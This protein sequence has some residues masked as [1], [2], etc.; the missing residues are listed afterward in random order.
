MRI[1]EKDEKGYYTLDN[2]G[3]RRKLVRIGCVM[4]PSIRFVRPNRITDHCR[5]C[6]YVINAFK[7]NS[8]IKRPQRGKDGK[9][10]KDT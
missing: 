5:K 3:Y 1:V 10:K 9:Y 4:C 8:Y 2:R 7:I 6:A